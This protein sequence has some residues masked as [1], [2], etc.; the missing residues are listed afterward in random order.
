[1]NCWNREAQRH[2]RAILARSGVSHKRLV[3]RL[4]EIGVHTTVAAIANRIHRGTLSFAFILQ[5]ARALHLDH[6]ELGVP[7]LSSD[8]DPG[9]T[10]EPRAMHEKRTATHAAKHESQS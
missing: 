1:M 7:Q 10:L 2:F 8:Q 4:A 9:R 5:V 6:L 3:L